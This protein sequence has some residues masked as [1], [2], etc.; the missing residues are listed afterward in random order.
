MKL[1]QSKQIRL[2]Q[3]QEDWENPVSLSENRAQKCVTTTLITTVIIYY[4]CNSNIK[5]HIM[6]VTE[7]KFSRYLLGKFS[8][9]IEAW[10]NKK[11]LIYNCNSM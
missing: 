1:T 11:N 8:V 3:L 2:L 9:F 10:Y 5:F 7:F 6:K 4:N